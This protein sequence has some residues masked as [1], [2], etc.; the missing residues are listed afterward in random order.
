MSV[1]INQ[2]SDSFYTATVD[3]GP[4]FAVEITAGE[5]PKFD[6]ADQ[7][8]KPSTVTRSIKKGE[9]QQSIKFAA[10]GKDNRLPNHLLN[11]LLNNNL[12]PGVMDTKDQILIGDDLVFYYEEFLDGK[13]VKVPFYSEVHEEFL[14]E[15]EA[16]QYLEEA[17][18]DY[19]WFSNIFAKLSYG[20]PKGDK[21]DI[22]TR[23]RHIDATDCRISVMNPDTKKSEYCGIADWLS[24]KST[25][26]VTILPLYNPLELK[27]E[28]EFM[29]HCKKRTPGNPYYPLPPYVG[30]QHWLRHANRIPIWKISNMENAANIKYHIQIPERYFMNLY[31]DPDFN[32]EDRRKKRE[33]LIDHIT[34]ILAGADNVSKT[35]YSEFAVDA[36][37]GKELPGWK[38]E[39]I[40]NNIQHEAYSKDFN[41]SNSAILSSMSLDPTLSNVLL[42]SGLGGTGAKDRE[43]YNVALKKTRYGRALLLRPIEIA[44]KI[45]KLDRLELEG[46]ERRIYIGIQDEMFQTL[47]VNPTGKTNVI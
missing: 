27:Q 20:N 45:N 41:D 38:I 11:L 16:F 17:A 31:P 32:R 22:I 13:K 7:F 25:D 39:A 46:K 36:V 2:V 8:T 35:F 3:K 23:I 37:T 12:A 33:E 10:W 5:A 40:P 26:K 21:A 42:P 18:I 19:N 4:G 34:N 9:K 47:D 24:N 44:M 15:I 30:A 1:K 29:I 43:A 14:E 6:P 28:Q